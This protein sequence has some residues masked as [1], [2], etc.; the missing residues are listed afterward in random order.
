MRDKDK[1]EVD[2][3]IT[4]DEEPWLLVEVKAA[5]SEHLSKQLLYF[6]EKVRAEHVFQIAFDMDYVDRDCFAI[7]RPVIVPIKTFLSQ[8]V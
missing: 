8:L 2:F 5:A 1:R 3:L 4:K 6:Q 7:K